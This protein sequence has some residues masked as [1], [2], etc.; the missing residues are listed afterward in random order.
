M[1]VF[2]DK[3][4]RNIKKVFQSKR[5]GWVEDGM[6]TKLDKAFARPL[7]LYRSY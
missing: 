7:Y 3:E 6:V 1:R 4:L 5:L 2:G